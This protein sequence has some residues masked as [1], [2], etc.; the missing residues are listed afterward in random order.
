MRRPGDRKITITLDPAEYK[1]IAQ[2]A[3]SHEME[4]A[5]YWRMVM[6]YYL[7]NNNVPIPC[8]EVRRPCGPRRRV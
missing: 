2:L 1:D 3:A 8:I 7:T 6:N 5:G 4:M